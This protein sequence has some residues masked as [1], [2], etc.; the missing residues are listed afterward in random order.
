MCS[1]SLLG[2]TFMAQTEAVG[3]C[4]LV[5]NDLRICSCY[6]L[7][8]KNSPVQCLPWPCGDIS[9]HSLIKV[10]LSILVKSTV[11]CVCVTGCTSFD[12]HRREILKHFSHQSILGATYPDQLCL[13]I[14]NFT[15]FSRGTV[16]AV[17]S[18]VKGPIW[19]C[20][21]TRIIK[22]SNLCASSSCRS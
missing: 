17:I 21:Q 13:T 2:N 6:V 9:M 4:T 3:A 8:M 15:R 14:Q 7:F 16:I 20:E 12:L 10:Y 22:Q 18:K 11:W 19:S 1:I 5:K